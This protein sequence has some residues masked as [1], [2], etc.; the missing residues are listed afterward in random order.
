MKEQ[1]ETIIHEIKEIVLQSAEDAETFRLKY[2]SRKGLL[3]DLMEKFK[4]IPNQEKKDIG[5][6]MNELKVSL[7]DK[8]EQAQEKFS[9]KV[10]GKEQTEDLSMPSE[11]NAIGARHPLTIVQNRILEIFNKLGFT[12]SEGPEIEDDWHN[13]SALNFPENHP[14]RDMQDT[15]F[16][17]KTTPCA[18]I[19][20]VCR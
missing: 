5:K 7:Q 15:F 10:A 1:L 13:F 19:V 12:I 14:A 4:E 2:L 6:I 3:N 9:R 18:H 20:P 8:L 16:I 17:D 11:T